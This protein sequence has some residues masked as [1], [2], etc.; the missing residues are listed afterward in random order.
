MSSPKTIHYL[1]IIILINYISSKKIAR[2]TS[3]AN[4]QENPLMLKFSQWFEDRKNPGPFGSTHQFDSTGCVLTP[5]FVTEMEDYKPN[6]QKILDTILKGNFKA[7]AYEDLTTFVDLFGH[8]V[9]GGGTMDKAV[10]YLGEKMA[11]LKLSN[12]HEEV[13]KIPVWSKGIEIAMIIDPV[14]V[15]LNIRALG[16]T[17]ETPKDGITAPILVVHSFSELEEQKDDVKISN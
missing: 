4:I 16:L 3:T 17:M 5:E 6:V 8:R 2:S 7:V 15:E 12:L 9:S 11:D 10:T 13:T 1:I 14:E